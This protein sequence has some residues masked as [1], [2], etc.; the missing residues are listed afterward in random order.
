MPSKHGAMSLPKIC[1]RDLEKAALWLTAAE[2]KKVRAEIRRLS[3][4]WD[5]DA[6]PNHMK[7]NTFKY[8]PIENCDHLSSYFPIEN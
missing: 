8:F 6:V 4:H 3:A 7:T 1:L 5:V 2:L